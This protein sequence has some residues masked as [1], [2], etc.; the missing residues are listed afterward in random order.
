M[1]KFLFLDKRLL[2]CA[3]FIFISIAA[4]AEEDKIV[5]TDIGLTTG[6]PVY[7]KNDDAVSIEESRGI[8][9]ITS[10]ISFR[11]A[12]PLRFLI[13]ADVTADL[14]FDGSDYNHHLDYAG[15]AGIRFYPG[16][17]NLAFSIAYAIGSRTDFIC[18]SDFEKKKLALNSVEYEYYEKSSKAWSESTAWGNG[19]R[20]GFDYDL[21]YNNNRRVAPAFGGYYRCMPRG[22]NNW[23]NIFAVYI[24]LGF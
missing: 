1:K 18:E 21:L 13:G 17:G 3:A 9:G 10:D 6:I 5:R 2:T 14:M 23:D 19:F 24:N 7:G 20:I 22:N 4:F 12:N 15:W 16:L 11:L 8:F